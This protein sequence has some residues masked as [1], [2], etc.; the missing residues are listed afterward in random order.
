MPAL[1]RQFARHLHEYLFSTDWV[2]RL[3]AWVTLLLQLALLGLTA[4]ALVE[5]RWLVAFA[6]AA[7]L[8]LTF[9]PAVIEHEFHLR[10]PVEFTFLNALFLYAAFGLGEVRQFYE[11]FWWWDLM[12]HSVSAVVL[13]W[14]GFLSV[15]VVYHGRRLRIAPFYV[16]AGSFGF[17]VTL[18]TLWEIF[19]YLMDHF[20]GF[21]MQKS[22]LD[23][24]MTDLIVDAGGALLAAWSGYHY[25]K[26]GDSLIAERLIRRFVARNP[27][28]FP[29]R[30]RQRPRRRRRR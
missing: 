13:G 6:A 9:L 10:L 12:L 3:Q 22:G 19:E 29:P 1:L 8:L 26:N 14:I 30:R 24:T 7:V 23:D 5:G 18:G 2:E 17:A 25:I 15:Y 16:A 11:R 20:F 27:R 28:L 4:G 21:N